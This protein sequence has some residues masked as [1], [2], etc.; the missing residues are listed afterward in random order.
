MRNQL[1]YLLFS[2]LII[3]TK[4]FIFSSSQH[5]RG[6][7]SDTNFILHSALF[8][9]PISFHSRQTRCSNEEISSRF[10]SQA[11]SHETPI[12]FFRWKCDGKI[13]SIQRFRCVFF[14]LSFVCG[15]PLSNI[16]H[17]FCNNEMSPAS[18]PDAD[19][20]KRIAV[21]IWRK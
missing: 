5:F 21:R 17:K 18:R 20:G 16:Q 14:S 19:R 4:L 1:N 2:I 11:I 9:P 7:V 8:F 13:A 15:T 10:P 12:C 3:G 6:F